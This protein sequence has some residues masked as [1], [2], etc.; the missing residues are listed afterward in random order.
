MPPQALFDRNNASIDGLKGLL[1][2]APGGADQSSLELEQMRALAERRAAEAA[3]LR[4]Q[5]EQKDAAVEMLRNN[6]EAQVR[7]R[8][9][10]R[11]CG[12]AL[13]LLPPQP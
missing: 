1:R 6:Y 8:A 10:A 11:V 2:G 5:L 9:R 4:N 12:A 3:V 7:H 13:A